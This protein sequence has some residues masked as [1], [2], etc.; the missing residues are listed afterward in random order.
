M[1]REDRFGIKSKDGLGGK[2]AQ[3]TGENPAFKVP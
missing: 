2:L 1:K 3:D